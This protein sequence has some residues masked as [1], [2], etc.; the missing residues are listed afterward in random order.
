MS[1][2]GVEIRATHR[3]LV[4][5]QDLSKV[6]ALDCVPAEKDYLRR[7]ADHLKIEDAYFCAG[8]EMEQILSRSAEQIAR[9]SCKTRYCA[10]ELRGLAGSGCSLLGVLG[11]RL[12]LESNGNQLDGIVWPKVLYISAKSPNADALGSRDVLGSRGDVPGSRGDVL[13]SR[14]DVLGS[15]DNASGIGPVDLAEL[16]GE[17][18]RIWTGLGW[19]PLL[20]ACKSWLYRELDMDLILVI[21]H[22]TALAENWSL[23][24]KL[25]LPWLDAKIGVLIINQEEDMLFQAAMLD[26]TN[27]MA[28]E[29]SIIRLGG[30]SDS[31][32][33]ES[34]ETT[35]VRRSSPG[36]RSRT[37]DDVKSGSGVRSTSGVRSASGIRSTSGIKFAKD[38]LKSTKDEL[39]SAKSTKDETKS[40]NTRSGG[41]S[42]EGSL[43]EVPG[44]S[45]SSAASPPP[46][47]SFEPYETGAWRSRVPPRPRDY[48][49][50]SVMEELVRLFL[51]FCGGHDE[52]L[53]ADLV[54]RY[55]QMKTGGLP[56]LMHE[57]CDKLLQDPEA[58]SEGLY[59]TATEILS[60]SG[61]RDDILASSVAN[62]VTLAQAG[63]YSTPA[64]LLVEVSAV[65]G[66]RLSIGRLSTSRLS[67]SRL[68]TSRLSASRL[69]ASRLSAS[70]GLQLD[71]QISRRAGSPGRRQTS[72]CT[73]RQPSSEEM[74]SRE[75]SGEFRMSPFALSIVLKGVDCRS[76]TSPRDIRERRQVLLVDRISPDKDAMRRSIEPRCD[77]QVVSGPETVSCSTQLRTFAPFLRYTYH[78]GLNAISR[79]YL[80]F[81]PDD[82]DQ[83]LSFSWLGLIRYMLSA[84]NFRAKRH[85]YPALIAGIHS[86]ASTAV[87]RCL[88]PVMFRLTLAAGNVDTGHHLLSSNLLSGNSLNRL[89][90]RNSSVGTN[91]TTKW[92]KQLGPFKRIAVYC[93]FQVRSKGDPFPWKKI[94]DPYQQ[95]HSFYQAFSKNCRAISQNQYNEIV[96]YGTTS[97][98]KG[99][100]TII[101]EAF[102]KHIIVIGK[103]VNK[104][105]SL[106]I[107]DAGEDKTVLAHKI[108]LIQEHHP[109]VKGRMEIR[110]CEAPFLEFLR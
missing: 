53:A 18:A 56:K 98:D 70:R 17:A 25:L 34:L 47:R 12:L 2:V 66:G 41:L 100:L 78:S 8:R 55:V 73:R 13:G 99:I 43:E 21:D 109:Q 20:N 93:G 52:L 48:E 87:W 105:I 54:V 58:A 102:A 104:G 103:H 86:W 45:F 9:S 64:H 72:T 50:K 38:D 7:V 15:R 22:A 49:G 36:H 89:A 88:V 6:L 5:S 106:I 33:R 28:A 30:L 107:L 44:R 24:S 101:L 97:I 3:W 4:N 81:C 94:E 71:A 80:R 40:A 11:G 75:L 16:L 14:G 39:K 91:S 10:I 85:V 29:R 42:D 63:S 60:Q 84:D 74:Y 95:S 92:D 65:S 82:K 32:V 110:D 57:L 61:A 31:E 83:R 62:I 79:G 1:K 26:P 27:P 68:S 77:L 96:Q 67:V 59:D 76:G 51:P 108:E 46:E 35:R 37:K 90:H 69:S 19:R 23:A